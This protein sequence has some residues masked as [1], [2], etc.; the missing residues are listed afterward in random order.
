[1]WRI[2]RGTFDTA[3]K[4]GCT[5]ASK[6]IEI[7]NRERERVRESERDREIGGRYVDGHR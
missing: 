4:K 3:G 1:M 7:E 5:S 6:Q 2:E